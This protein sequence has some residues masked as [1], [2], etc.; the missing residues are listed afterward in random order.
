MIAGKMIL[1]YFKR[2]KVETI[3]IDSPMEI[4]CQKTFNLKSLKYIFEGKDI[5]HH[6]A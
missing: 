1:I 4:F 6:S 2:N 3:N 5:L